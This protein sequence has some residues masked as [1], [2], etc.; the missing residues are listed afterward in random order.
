MPGLFFASAAVLTISSAF[1]LRAAEAEK[2][3]AAQAKE[4]IDDTAFFLKSLNQ[5]FGG[6]SGSAGKG[7]ED[8]AKERLA[9]LQ[10]FLEPLSTENDE[11]KKLLDQAKAVAGQFE[12]RITS[13]IEQ[14]K[15]MNAFVGFGEF[16]QHFLFISRFHLVLA[17][18]GSFGFFIPLKI[19]VAGQA[20]DFQSFIAISFL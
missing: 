18:A 5:E 2:I 3:T 1:Q 14:A 16:S 8:A 13:I 12:S 6:I 11:S 15:A 4:K 19:V 17:F 7:Q 10:K 9:A 20:D